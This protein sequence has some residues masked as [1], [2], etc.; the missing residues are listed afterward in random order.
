LQGCIHEYAIFTQVKRPQTNGKAESEI[1][2][3]HFNT[4]NIAVLNERIQY[5][6]GL[7]WLSGQKVGK[8]TRQN[9]SG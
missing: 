1:K 2:I 8:V 6:A 4:P 5:I 7:V 9:K 3:S